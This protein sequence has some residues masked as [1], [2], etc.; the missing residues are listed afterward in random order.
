MTNFLYFAKAFMIASAIQMVSLPRGYG[1]SEF[2]GY[3][4]AFNAG[5]F[6]D[7]STY[8]SRKGMTV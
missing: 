6:Q 2:A 8:N 7:E 3:R 4:A 1:K 5:G